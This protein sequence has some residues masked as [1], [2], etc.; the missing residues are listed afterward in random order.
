MTKVAVMGAGAVGSYLGSRLMKAGAG[1]HL[2][3]RG[4]HLDVL[5]KSG[6]TLITPDGEETMHIAA[7]DD[8]ATIG[9]VDVVLFGVKSYDT[10]AAVA[11]LEPLLGPT[12]AVVSFQNGIDNEDK[13]AAVI[14]ADHV[15][16]AAVYILA[17][18]E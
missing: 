14:G 16:S 15:V 1:V 4:K 8:P 5:R 13:I 3:A 9:P 17:A 11:Q 7:T 6:L 10:E 18:I 12:T 2:I